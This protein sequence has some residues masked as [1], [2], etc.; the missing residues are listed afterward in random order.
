MRTLLQGKGWDFTPD[1]INA[2]ATAE[3][4][5][6]FREEQSKWIADQIRSK[7]PSDREAYLKAYVEA[8]EPHQ[9]DY[10]HVVGTFLN[11]P[12]NEHHKLKDELRSLRK[13]VELEEFERKLRGK[14]SL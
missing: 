11:V 8:S 3:A 4:D 2:F 7:S 14:T 6:Q 10:L 9:N 12:E 13:K 5:S 1:E